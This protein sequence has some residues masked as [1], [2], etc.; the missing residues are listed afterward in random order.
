MGADFERKLIEEN[1]ELRERVAEL[2]ERN[3]DLAK[4]LKANRLELKS[5]SARGMPDQ[6]RLLPISRC[7]ECIHRE[8]G[9]KGRVNCRLTNDLLAYAEWEIPESC[10]L[11][12]LVKAQVG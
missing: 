6:N 2:R 12:L 5:A 10:P 11:P 3:H 4:V 7:S 9:E 1:R 8:V